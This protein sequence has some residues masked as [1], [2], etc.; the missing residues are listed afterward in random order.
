MIDTRTATHLSRGKEMQSGGIV[1]AIGLA[2]GVVRITLMDRRAHHIDTMY[3]PG[4]AHAECLIPRQ[5]LESGH[6][7]GLGVVG[8]V[9]R[10]VEEY[11]ICSFISLK[12]LDG[13]SQSIGFEP[14]IGIEE[15]D[16]LSPCLLQCHVASK[17]LPLVLFQMKHHETF[18]DRSI[19]LQDRKGVV[20]G[21]I[22]DTDHLNV[23]Q[24]LS[25][26]RVETG[27]QIA[28]CIVDGNENSNLSHGG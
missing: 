20:G 13:T 19:R 9:H 27:W 24:R 8:I 14:V 3:L 16:I 5:H 21:S 28:R 22:V 1:V 6:S 4:E 15:A 26:Q 23:A 25:S 7:I 10:H 2:G 18:I 12:H 11:G 17:G